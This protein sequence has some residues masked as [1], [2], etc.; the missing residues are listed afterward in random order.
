MPI[1]SYPAM[2]PVMPPE[3][4]LR[5]SAAGIPLLVLVVLIPVMPM[6]LGCSGERTGAVDMKHD[7][8]AI[9][10]ILDA[11]VLSDKPSREFQKALA[12]VRAFSS[13]DSAWTDGTSFFVKYINGGVVTWTAPPEPR[14]QEIH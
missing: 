11:A 12:P 6:L 7:H 14:I 5:T 10:R 13:V 4:R 2:N 3:S 1:V 9:S 8:E